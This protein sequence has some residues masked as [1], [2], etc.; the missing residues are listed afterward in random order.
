MPLVIQGAQ[1][2]GT[3]FTTDSQL[4]VLNRTP[5]RY[6]YPFDL[7]LHPGSE[8]HRRL[9]D[10]VMSRVD[11]CRRLMMPRYQS[12]RG[13]DETMG[14]FIDISQA[15]KD[16]KAKDPTKP[17]PIVIPASYAT[18]QILLTYMVAAFLQD[19]IFK[20]DGIGPED[21]PGAIIMEHLVQ[22]QMKKSKAALALHT[23]WSDAY[24]YNMGPGL[25]KWQKDVRVVSDIRESVG[26]FADVFMEGQKE[27]VVFEGNMIEAI[28][29]YD[30]I[31]DVNQQAHD[32]QEMEYVGW[33]ERRS[34]MKV[35]QTEDIDPARFNGRFLDAIDGKSIY[36]L[37]DNTGRSQKNENTI[38]RRSTATVYAKPV[39]L[40]H[41][42]I[43]L[44]PEQ[45]GLGDSRGVE[46]WYFVVAG[47]EIIIQ[48]QPLG[49]GHGRKP[50]TCM[51]PD[52]DGHEVA[53][54]SRLERESG[55]QTFINFLYNSRMLNLRK[56]INNQV[57]IDP[58]IINY[59][60][61]VNAKAGGIWRARRSK[62]GLGLLEKGI[63]PIP[64]QDVTANMT[65]DFAVMNQVM[66]NTSGA[67]DIL[68]AGAFP[69]RGERVSATEA[70]G[71]IQGSLLWIEKDA[72]IMWAQGMQDFG[73]MAGMNLQ[74]MMEQE[75]YVR[76]TGRMVDQIISEFGLS[77]PSEINQL[78]EFDITQ[79]RVLASPK[80]LG[81]IGFDIVP[82]DVTES[83][84][85]G[86][87]QA[88]VQFL[89]VITQNPE[90]AKEFDIFRV[91][92][93]VARHMGIKDVD[94]W[95]RRR[96]LPFTPQVQPDSQVQEGVQS[97]N[98]API[99]EVLSGSNGAA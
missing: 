83:A 56:A 29:P 5:E 82:I 48:A 1:L 93:S 66:K 87:P 80:D 39:D 97:G 46:T 23:M 90:V 14:A 78:S 3:P 52:Y 6:S 60:D 41:L 33:V 15:E 2:M 19:P 72:R 47:D 28:D 42:Y 55:V 24:K 26:V 53:P 7:D 68:G 79:N 12:W 73:E 58:G 37:N 77:S 16:V 21:I 61:V 57:G 32:I 54:I 35:L 31:F 62:W 18:L 67:P 96:P 20:Y 45:W 4:S 85:S 94:A 89:N 59:N 10:E 71:A 86:D 63:Y 81:Q 43:D 98:V 17:V 34:H 76:M 84:V 38:T 50:V 74:E 22:A 9:R 49:A 65:N 40:V 13:I 30:Y 69:R 27:T 64:V 70:G 36:F 99:N 88:S 51:S 91:T 92:K 11:E 8:L 44:V 95:L 75:T 25:I